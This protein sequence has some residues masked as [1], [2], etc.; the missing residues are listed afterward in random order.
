MLHKNKAHIYKERKK[1]YEKISMVIE[2]GDLMAS[3]QHWNS[4]NNTKSNIRQNSLI[5]EMPSTTEYTNQY[6]KLKM[7]IILNQRVLLKLRD[8]TT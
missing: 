7:F 1:S 5:P 8:S 3:Y 4:E 2:Y 6:F